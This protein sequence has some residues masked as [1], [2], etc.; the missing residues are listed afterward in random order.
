MEIVR[1][2]MN[3]DNMQMVECHYN[4]VIIQIPVRLFLAMTYRM[5]FDNRKFIRYKEGAQI[6]GMSEREFI[7]LAHDAKAVYKRNKIAMVNVEILD[8]FM[9]TYKVE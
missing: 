9:Q 5:Q 6:Y 1:K 2:D 7:K 4:G 8:K 3:L